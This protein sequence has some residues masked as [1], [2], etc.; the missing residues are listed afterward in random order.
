MKIR[1][2]LLG[3]TLLFILI[4]VTTPPSPSFA[5]G[6]KTLL[7]ITD[8]T[9][10]AAYYGRYSSQGALLA[11]RE[12]EESG[13]NLRIIVEDSGMK[14][15]TALSVITR[16]FAERKIDVVVSEFSIPT[17]PVSAALR[18]KKVPLFAICVAR[19]FM[20]E[21][22]LVLR[23]YVDYREG[24]KL[25]AEHWKRMGLRKVGALKAITEFGE[26]CLEGAKEVFPNIVVQEF[27]LSSQVESQTLKLRKEGVEALLSP[28]FEGDTLNLLRTLK[29]LHWSPFLGFDAHDSLTPVV[30]KEF[31][32]EIKRAVGFGFQD[33]PP[34]L[35]EKLRKQ[36]PG[37]TEQGL[38]AGSL[39]YLHVHQLYR[40]MTNCKEGDPSSCII[41]EVGNEQ[42]TDNL[43]FKRFIDREAQFD[44][45]LY[46]AE[47]T[48]LKIA[49]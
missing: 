39:A 41:R 23:S 29:K 10:V 30:A 6:Q 31:P 40:A 27:E 24:C 2:Y 19:S 47:G 11:Q 13:G 22:P 4:G 14:P 1:H 45:V 7:Y 49:E 35:T 16:H 21:N 17:I 3:C 26:L 43:G 42:A 38:R 18:E 20:E 28:A 48:A 15:Q 25:I 37:I 8:L 44:Y 5:D 9:G 46:Q 36:S 34:S 12:I 33:P 32:H